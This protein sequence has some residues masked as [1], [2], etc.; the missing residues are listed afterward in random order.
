[1]AKNNK[2]FC[3]FYDWMDSL[4]ELDP[5]DAYAVIRAISR[6]NETGEDPTTG[7]KGA[8]KAFVMNL[9]QQIKRAEETSAAKAEGAR[10]TNEK[11]ANAERTHTERIPNAERTDESATNTNTITNTDTNTITDTD[12]LLS[13][14]N[15]GER[16][17]EKKRFVPPTVDEVFAYMQERGE[18][19]FT[20]AESFVDYYVNAKWRVGSSRTVM[21]DWK[22][23]VRNW[24]RRERKGKP[25]VKEKPKE[26]SFDT[27]DFFEASLKRSYA[28]EVARTDTSDA[29]LLSALKASVGVTA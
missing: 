11:R 28:N 15:E 24:L 21:T 23:A 9:Y 5:A 29:A 19:D 20:V 17:R 8:L 4:D 25:K 27:D 10:I 6:Y 13:P 1:M 7:F 16:A 2:G 14:S 26:S 3:L 22:A 18:T 12:T